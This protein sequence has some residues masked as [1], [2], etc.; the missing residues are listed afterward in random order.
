MALARQPVAAGCRAG[1]CEPAVA[2]PRNCAAACCSGQLAGPSGRLWAGSYWAAP[3]RRLHCWPA[4]GRR[5]QDRDARRSAACCAQQ[6]PSQRFVARAA[7]SQVVATSVLVEE[8]VEV[9]STEHRHEAARG[10]REACS[11]DSLLQSVHSVLLEV[12]E[13]LEDL[14]WSADGFTPLT[15]KPWPRNLATG[16]RSASLPQW[17]LDIAQ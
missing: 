2:H 10:G 12:G 16:L 17:V 7:G 6:R 3:L 13:G 4:V 14:V 8:A 1:D 15:V 11:T 5:W 9:G